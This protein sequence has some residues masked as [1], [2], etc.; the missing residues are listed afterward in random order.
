[1]YPRLCQRLL[2]AIALANFDFDLGWVPSAACIMNVDFHVELIFEMVGPLVL[3]AL[4]GLTYTI[5]LHRNRG[6]ERALSAVRR[7]HANATIATTLLL[8]SMASSAVFRSFACD[9]LVDGYVYLRSDYRIECSSPKRKAFQI[10]AA[11]MI[12]VYPLGIPTLFALLLF[13]NRK[14]LEDTSLRNDNSDL[15]QQ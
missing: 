14:G 1:M 7:K 6:S 2:D 3:V 5:A 4:G 12:V 11:F 15:L 9:P 8:Y 10:Y 13:R